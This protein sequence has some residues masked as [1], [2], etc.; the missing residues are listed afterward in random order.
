MLQEL[1]ATH[2]LEILTKA[3]LRVAARDA[4]RASEEDLTAGLPRFLDQLLEALRR[5]AT[6]EAVDHGQIE[7]SAGDHGGRL[8]A[9]GASVAQ[10]VHDYGDLCQVITG[11]AVEQHAILDPEEFRTL[12]LCLDDAIAGAVTEHARLR[13]GHVADAGTERLG[14]LAHEMRNILNTAILSFGSM[15]RGAVGTAG[16]TGVLHARS[17]LQLSSLIDRSLAAV[18]LESGMNHLERV[19]VREILE[20]VEIGASM[21][22]RARGLKLDVRFIDPDVTVA[23]DRQIVAGAV[24]NLVQNAL[25]FT[26]AGTTVKLGARAIEG[27]V[28]IE[29]EDECGGLPPG[30]AEGLLRPFTQRGHDR[31]GLGLGLAICVKAVKTMAGEVRILDRPGVGCTFTIDLP[32]QAPL[33][34]GT[35]EDRS[36][37]NGDAGAPPGSV[38][39]NVG[40]KTAEGGGANGR[41]G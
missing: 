23:A 19:P 22:A 36:A 9:H 15:Q 38:R 4:P 14:F 37:K 13:E 17:L 10:V 30:D 34:M 20:E 35:S 26:K 7:Q 25:K 12:N 41:G 11:L 31:T 39:G 27:R 3:R 18:R 16:S 33:A 32:K 40:E 1:I 24:A 5:D 6:H 21:A 2:R 28:L 8:F 29:V